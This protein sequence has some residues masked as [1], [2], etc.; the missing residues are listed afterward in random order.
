MALAVGTN[1]LHKFFRYNY[2]LVRVELVCRLDL[3][4]KSVHIL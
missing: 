4:S 1:W 3:Q 2:A